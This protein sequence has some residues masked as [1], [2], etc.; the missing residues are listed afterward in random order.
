MDERETKHE[1]LS[2]TDLL[3]LERVCLEFEKHWS[4][5][6]ISHIAGLVLETEEHLQPA[7][8]SELVAL[9]VENRRSENE[10]FGAELYLKRLPGYAHLVREQVSGDA[11][12][13]AESQANSSSIPCRI[14][15]YRIV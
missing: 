15:D 5:D 6:S 8:V 9:D 14:G 10:P 12:N 3:E 13:F 4:S 7:V 2:K 1:I 11:S